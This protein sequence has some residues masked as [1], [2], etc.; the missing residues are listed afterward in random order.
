MR[1]STASGSPVTC[2]PKH[3]SLIRTPSET[4]Y[5]LSASSPGVMDGDSTKTYLVTVPT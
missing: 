5:A 3:V 4:S 1:R 2:S